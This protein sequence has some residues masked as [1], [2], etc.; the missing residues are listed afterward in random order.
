VHH[1]L[2]LPIFDELSDPRIVA[3]LSAEAEETGW[4]GVF[5]W[6]HVVY[7]PPAAA[8]AN[9]WVTMA[10]M[11]VATERVRIGPMVTPLPRRRPLSVAREMTTLDLLSSGRTTLGVGIASDHHRELSATGEVIGGRERGAML[12]EA[13]DVLTA[14]WSG[15]AVHH[16]GEHYVVDGLT[17]LPRPAQR[18]HPPVWVGLRY[19]SQKP[20]RRAAR[21]QGVFPVNVREPDQ[22]A[23]VVAGVAEH[24]EP[25]A[26]ALDVVLGM[27]P[28]TDP[29]PYEAVG[30]TWWLEA[31]PV[32]STVD[33]V[34]AI[35]RSG[36]N[37]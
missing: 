22:L 10:A 21:F 28:G 31:F 15:Q 26:G 30:A 13:L 7:S 1:A 5:V 37:R 33:E 4:D 14:A 34:R 25:D 8:V 9:P 32:G 12:D 3:R 27:K 35:L 20:L 23:E 29:R 18:P 2:F 6:D 36:P 16:R 17:I 11:A 24:R 19:G